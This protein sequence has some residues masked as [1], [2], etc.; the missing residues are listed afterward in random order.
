M[1]IA[2]CLQLP[3]YFYVSTCLQLSSHP[4]EDLG[5]LRGT[6]PLRAIP[7]LL[8]VQSG[9]QIS[10]APSYLQNLAIRSPHSFRPSPITHFQFPLVR[11]R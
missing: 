11:L 5:Y 6:E 10:S 2:D 8:N 9:F 7:D 4:G 1:R 3:T